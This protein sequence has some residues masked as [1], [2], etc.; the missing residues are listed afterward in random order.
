MKHLRLFAA[1]AATVAGLV[2]CKP[3]PQP[4]VIELSVSPSSVTFEADGGTLKVAVSTNADSYSVTGAPSWL[5]VEQNGKEIALT[6]EQNTITEEKKAT[7]TVTAADK[8]SKIEVSQKA[9]SPY[10]GYT[11]MTAADLEYAGTMLYQFIKP[12]E[13]YDGGSA[14]LSLK[15][16]DGNIFN[17]WIYTELFEKEEDVE[18]TTGTYTKGKDN[19]PASL[20]AKKLTYMPG[21]I[22][23][24]EDEEEGD[25]MGTYYENGTSGESAILTDGT[26]EV[27][28]SAEGYTVKVDMTDPDGN[29]YKFVYIG[30]VELDTESATY[31]SGN[32][33]ADVA[34]TI[35]DAEC[36]YMGDVFDNGTSTFILMLFAGD[37]DN[38][39]T[40]TYQFVT[41]GMDFSEDMDITGSYAT[42]MA[43]EEDE[44]VD[45]YGEGAVISGE[46]TELFPGFSFPSGT[47]I[48]Y[49]AS[50]IVLGDAF[51]TLNLEKQA[52]GSYSF[53]GVISSLDGSFTMFGIPTPINLSFEIS[54]EA[55][56]D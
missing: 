38:P 14:F 49:S 17:A 46:L 30:E 19:Y 36:Y 53:T 31:P 10:A 45:P 37:E 22:L 29:E 18:F 13:G 11:L 9:G 8:T 42:A 41:K 23:Q 52:D 26:I 2:A 54:N 32:E 21:F 12:A 55:D 4:V 1:I 5:K 34:N 44:E 56:I 6:A 24:F 47:Y 40:V 27:S 16:E 50:D 33:R 28:E 7:L 39:A 3:E 20:A 48:M 15:D 35:Y 25:I 51:N 43:E